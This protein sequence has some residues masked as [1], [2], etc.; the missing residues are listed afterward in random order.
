MKW[1]WGVLVGALMLSAAGPVQCQGSAAQKSK[2]IAL[3]DAW[4]QAQLHRDGSA[5]QGLVSDDYIYTDTDGSLS[6]KAKFISDIKDPAMQMTLLTNDN[7]EVFLYPGVAIVIGEY[8]AKGKY[9]G[10]AFDH[11]GRFTDT[12]IRT[13]DEWQCVATHTNLIKK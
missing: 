5:L 10:K 1:A 7:M 9:Q 3:E 4:N 11:Y 6:N 12:W 13:K 8:H 2:L